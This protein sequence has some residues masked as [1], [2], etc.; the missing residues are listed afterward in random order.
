MKTVNLTLVAGLLFASGFTLA[1]GNLV[2]KW[3]EGDGTRQ[4]AKAGLSAHGDHEGDRY[5]AEADL[6]FTLKH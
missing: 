4:G 6:T 5:A 1:D 2:G 3:V